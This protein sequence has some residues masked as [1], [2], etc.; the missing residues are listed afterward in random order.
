MISDLLAIGHERP[1]SGKQLADA[2][3]CDIREVTAAI[4]RERRAGIPI[5]AGLDGYYLAANKAELTTYSKRLFK[6]AGN[7]MKT[8]RCLKKEIPRLPDD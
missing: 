6:R 7:L 5:C 1:T 4:E 3:G 8:Y 2:L